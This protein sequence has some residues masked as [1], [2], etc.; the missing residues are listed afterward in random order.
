MFQNGAKL[1]CRE[2]G[3]VMIVDIEGNITLGESAVSLREA[4]KK[5]LADGKRKI[6]LNLAKTTY[7]DGSGIAEMVS[8]F[9]TVSNRRGKLKLLNLTKRIQDLLQITKLYTVFETFADE[10]KA[11]ASFD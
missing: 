4:V 2:V 5:L 6:V 7:I 10:V 11:V 1:T 9:T 8:C 3:D